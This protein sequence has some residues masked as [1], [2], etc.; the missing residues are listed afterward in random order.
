MYNL[1]KKFLDLALL[2]GQLGF[3]WRSTHH[4]IQALSLWKFNTWH[5]SICIGFS[6]ADLFRIASQAGWIQWVVSQLTNSGWMSSKQATMATKGQQPASKPK[7][8]FQP[9]TNKF[10]GIY[11]W[12]TMKQFFFFFDKSTMKQ[13]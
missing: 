11:H 5:R 13:I 1:H 12:M 9:Q 6:T 3:G 4:S 2:I 10:F 8:S 7:I